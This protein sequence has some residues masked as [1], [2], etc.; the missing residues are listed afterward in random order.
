[1]NDSD[2]PADLVQ[3]PVFA[4][5]GG[6]GSFD[7]ND[8]LIFYAEDTAGWEYD[9]EAGEWT[10]YVNPFSS[11]NYYFL[12][13]AGEDGL[14]V[15]TAPFPAYVDATVFT[16]V[17]GR[18]YV[19][20]DRFNWNKQ[21]GSGLTWLSNPIDPTGRLDILRDSIPP[22]FQGGEVQFRARTAIKSNPSA[23]AYFSIGGAQ[24]A[25]IQAGSVR[26]GEEEPSARLADVSFTNA[27]AANEALDLSM[28]LQQQ[29]NNPEAALDWVRATYGQVLTPR[30]GM[31]RFATPAGISGRME[32]V[33]GGFTGEPRVWDITEPGAIRRLGAQS[34]GGAFRVQ[35]EV[36]EGEAPRELVAFI[37]SAAQSLDAAEAPTVAAQNLHGLQD[38]PD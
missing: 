27:F 28:T 15:E 12:K 14:R 31:V 37:E 16:T 34:S 21:N 11:Q 25:Q 36:P 2:R 26:P 6:D 4:R 5:G 3:N 22:G 38:Y 23:L 35:I 17:P 33:L 10:H 32:F 1:L 8:A 9:A 24:V 13:V 18:L 19:D 7:E 29:S 30:N 20:F